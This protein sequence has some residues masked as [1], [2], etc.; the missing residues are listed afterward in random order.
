MLAFVESYGRVAV[1]GPD[2]GAVQRLLDAGTARLRRRRVRCAER[3]PHLSHVRRQQ[4]AGAL[5]PEVR[6]PRRRPVALRPPPG[7][8]PDDAHVGVRAGRVADRRGDAVRP[9]AVAGR[10][11]LLRVRPRLRPVRARVRR[12]GVRLLLDARPVRPGRAR[13]ARAARATRRRPSWP[14]STSPPATG[15]GRRCRRRWT[16]R[17]SGTVPLFA[18]IRQRATT[19]TQLWSDRR[20]VPAAYRA[21]IA[22]SLESLIAFVGRHADDDLVVV[23]L[24]DHQP[25]TVVSGFGGEPRRAGH[26]ARS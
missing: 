10:A 16:R 4:L 18:G 9:R 25:S 14:R 5:H 19:P 8:R 12:A 6:G 21:S 1:E 22:Y 23:L 26:R 11:G 20:D 3:V 15:P 2:A 13:P 24:G 17:P 7:Q